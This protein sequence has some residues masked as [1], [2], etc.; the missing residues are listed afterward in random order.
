MGRTLFDKIWADHVVHR[1]PDGTDL[2]YIDRHLL[3]EATSAQPFAALRAAG[4]R[5]WR[6]SAGF[7][8]PDHSVPTAR[9]DRPIAD[10]IARLQVQA[11]ADNRRAFGI[12]GFDL[13]DPGQ[14]IVHVVGPEQGLSQPGSTIVCGDSHT[15]THGALAALAFGIGSSEVEHVLATQTLAVRKPRN[16]RI[17]LDGALPADV[18]AKDLALHVIRT[19]GTAGATGHAIEFAGPVVEALSIEAR[20][21]LCNL[22]IEAGAR[23]GLV[24]YDETTGRY[25]DGLAHTPTGAPG[26]AARAWWATLHSDASARFDR[27]LILDVTTLSPMVTWGTRPDM[28][29]ALDGVVPDPAAEL[30]DDPDA[31]CSARSACHPDGASGP[32]AARDADR[33]RAVAQALD[34]MALKPGMPIREIRPD[35]IFIGSCTNSRIED[36]RAAAAVV[37][38]R[39]IAGSIRRALVVPGSGLVKARA[40]A[41]GLDRIFIAAGFEWR[42][43][44]CSMCVGMNDDSL[45]RGE[46]CASTSNRNFEDRQGVGGRTHLV[47]PIVAAATAVLGHFGRPADLPPIGPDELAPPQTAAADASS[48]P[49]IPAP[50]AQDAAHAHS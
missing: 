4:R 35:V 30:F 19:L 21:T 34:Y 23:C 40:E 26:D 11:L 44:G 43:P 2:L 20:M 46:R 17:R 48:D 7:A 8:V 49:A 6:A 39:R 41:E 45:G 25:L 18:T 36:L 12:P 5:P 31:A 1:F 27:E 47:S 42:A 16:L 22:S 9:R 28:V 15:S 50:P 24:A 33:R 13:G 37:Q 29:E 10:P 32:D 38:G 3:H 14:G